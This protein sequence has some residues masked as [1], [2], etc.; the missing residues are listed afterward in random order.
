MFKQYIMNGYSEKKIKPL[1]LSFRTPPTVRPQAIL[2]GKMIPEWMAQCLEPVIITYESNGDWDIG[3]HEYQQSTPSV[4]CVVNGPLTV[5]GAVVIK[6][7]KD[8][9]YNFNEH[10]LDKYIRPYLRRQH[11][12]IPRWN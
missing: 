4:S 12:E 10:L 9:L 3:A 11:K 6:K 2:I 1:C 5:N 7:P 8:P